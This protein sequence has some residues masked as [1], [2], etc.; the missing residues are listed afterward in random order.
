MKK[1]KEIVVQVIEN[2]KLTTYN[3]KKFYSNK[4]GVLYLSNESLFIFRGNKEK[5]LLQ[6]K[7]KASGGIEALALSSFIVCV[8]QKA[9]QILL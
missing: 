3:F 7:E 1:K 2:G 5:F 9:D 4:Y 8:L 6:V